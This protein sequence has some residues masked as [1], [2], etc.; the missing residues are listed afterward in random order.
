MNFQTQLRKKFMVFSIKLILIICIIFASTT[1]IISLV[2]KNFYKNES[3]SLLDKTFQDLNNKIF[4][5]MDYHNSNADYLSAIENNNV[6]KK[7]VSTNNYSFYKSMNLRYNYNIYD[8]ELNPIYEEAHY[9]TLRYKM[10]LSIIKERIK[11]NNPI[12]FVIY[13]DLNSTNSCLIFYNGLYKND[14]LIG[15]DTYL[16]DINDLSYFLLPNTGNYIIAN[17]FDSIIASNNY[18]IL[19]AG[20]NFKYSR[21]YTLNGTKYKVTR[22]EKEFYTIYYLEKKLTIEKYYFALLFMLIAI[23][24]MVIFFSNNAIRKIAK[25]NSLSIESIINDSNVVSQGKLDH[26]INENLDGDFKKLAMNINA[27]LDK[28]NSEIRLNKQLSETNLIFEKRKLDSQFDPHFLYNSLETIRYSML[29]EVKETEKYILELNSILRY[30]ITNKINYSKLCEDLIYIK[31]YL[32]LDKF[33]FKDKLTYNIRIDDNMKDIL[34]PKLV[35]QPLVGNCIKYGFKDSVKVHIDIIA[36][37]IDNI[38][39]IKVQ[40]NGVSIS[41]EVIEE[42]KENCKKEQNPTNHIGVHNVLRRFMIL[43][44]DSKLS[45]RRDSNGTVFEISF[46]KKRNPNV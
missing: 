31:K 15:I 11:N 14:I 39:Y 18:E 33:R 9:S 3:I 46:T 6:T 13:S 2:G 12:K 45:V 27:M 4:F 30:S 24:L 23:V 21:N 37:M 32:E 10:Y 42:I 41:D 40:D 28:L 36:E 43:Y 20:V 16:I 26:K 1:L 29:F 25:E 8:A 22:V 38:C 19:K 17:K 44:P 34:V 7:L 5:Q 35:I